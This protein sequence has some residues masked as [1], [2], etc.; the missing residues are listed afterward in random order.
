[1]QSGS[2]RPPAED[3]HAGLFPLVSA[4][5]VRCGWIISNFIAF[6]THLHTGESKYTETDSQVKQKDAP[7]SWAL[8]AIQDSQRKTANLTSISAESKTVCWIYLLDVVVD[9][10]VRLE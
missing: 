9:L 1:M 3:R 5:T 8:T 7:A 6:D 10:E 2:R 4:V